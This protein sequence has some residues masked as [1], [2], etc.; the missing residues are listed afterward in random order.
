MTGGRPRRGGIRVALV[1]ASLAA[2]VC[3]AAGQ[4]G[5]PIDAGT[6]ADAGLGQSRAEAAWNPTPAD[7]TGPDRAGIDGE[8]EAAMDM[9]PPGRRVR[10][11]LTSGSTL[12]LSVSPY[13]AGPDGADC[14]VFD[15]DY[16]TLAG[17][18]AR[19]TGRRCWLAVTG[20]RPTRMD[21]LVE[22]DGLP[23]VERTPLF[24]PPVPASMTDGDRAAGSLNP[25]E[26]ASASPGARAGEAAASS[27]PKPAPSAPAPSRIILPFVLDDTRPASRR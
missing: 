18:H 14:R 5:E 9:T 7:I 17:G 15:Y 20:W 2:S 19:V 23:A 26:D 11:E 4:S 3:H 8:L 21:T 16:R 1:A 22:A 25:S 13:E 6:A 27:E 10:I 12:L 24:E